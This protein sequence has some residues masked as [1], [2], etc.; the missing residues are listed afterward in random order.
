M[1]NLYAT[2]LLCADG[3]RQK[4]PILAADIVDVAKQIATTLPAE[5]K[6]ITI[7]IMERDC[8][9]MT[10]EKLKECYEW[11]AETTMA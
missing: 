9:E 2:E 3:T 5:V 10:S 8:S 6:R 4:R 11:E 7:E 1:F